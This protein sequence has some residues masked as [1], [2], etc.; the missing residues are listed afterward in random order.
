MGG[1]AYT[2]A[3]ENKNR[4]L[5]RTRAKIRYSEG[6]KKKRKAKTGITNGADPRSGGF[7]KELA[8]KGQELESPLAF[9][10]F[11]ARALLRTER[12]NAKRCPRQEHFNSCRS[13]R[14]P[15]L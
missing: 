15:I 8:K 1:R 2:K 12:A 9:D 11:G 4:P 14:G 5:K 3:R 7:E 10:P 13:S 6:K